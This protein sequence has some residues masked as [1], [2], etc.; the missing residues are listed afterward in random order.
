MRDR[1]GEELQQAE[2]AVVEGRCPPALA[3][4][5]PLAVTNP[6]LFERMAAGPLAL[7]YSI[8]GF[9]PIACDWV[10]GQGSPP[11]VAWEG[12]TRGPVALLD[13]GDARLVI[14]PKQSRREDEIAAIAAEL[15]VGPRQHPTLPGFLTEDMAPGRFFTDLPAEQA[16]PDFL[17]GVGQRLGTMLSALHGRGICYNDATLSDP[18][19]RSHLLVTA[20]GDA[21]LI[22]FGVSALLDRHP[23]V[24]PEDAYNLLRTDPMFRVFRSMSP[25]PADV[26]ALV[27]QYRRR[28]AAMSME[29]LMSRDLRFTEQGIRLAAQRMGEEVAP[30][31]QQGFR[32]GYG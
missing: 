20:G 26:R 27:E 16:T 12:R 28:L 32:E 10:Y 8:Y 18:E 19:G 31:L 2:A 3:P 14:K 30:P 17:Y 7:T 6:T 25:T 4:L 22:D 11:T 5:W 23:A 29:E 21:L 15:G 1:S 9:F 13:H 24:D